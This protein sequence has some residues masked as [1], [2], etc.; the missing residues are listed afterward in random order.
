MMVNIFVIVGLGVLKLL[1]IIKKMH[2]RIAAFPSV[3]P[4]THCHPEFL[5]KVLYFWYNDNQ[6]QLILYGLH[7]HDLRFSSATRNLKLLSVVRYV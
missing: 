6:N 4:I 5:S 7:K 2:L 3:D 1:N